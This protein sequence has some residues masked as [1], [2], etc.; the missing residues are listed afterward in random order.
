MRLRMALQADQDME[1]RPLPETGARVYV[2]QSSGAA[3]QRA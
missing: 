3:K 1:V 2:P